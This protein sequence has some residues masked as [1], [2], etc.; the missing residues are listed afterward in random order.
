MRMPDHV[1][2]RRLESSGSGWWTGT[3]RQPARLPDP[4]ASLTRCATTASVAAAGAGAAA[5]QEAHVGTGAAYVEATPAAA[6][7]EAAAA[8]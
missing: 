8:A 6:V 5:A 7:E 2:S 1:N 4:A 3:S